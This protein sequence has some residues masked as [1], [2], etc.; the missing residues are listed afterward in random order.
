MKERK[1]ILSLGSNLG[2][3]KE[4][5][6]T[7]IR[8]IE[9]ILQTEVRSSSFYESTSWGFES[10]HPFL[11]NCV[12]L[13]SD[14]SPQDLLTSF[15]TVEKHMGRKKN[16]K[17]TRYVSRIIDIDILYVGDT[18]L[19]QPE[20]TIPHPLLYDRKFVLIPLLELFPD[21]IDPLKKQNI[22]ALI[23]TCNDQNEAIL[24][25]K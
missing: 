7:A 25:E 19:K 23:A 15:K 11:N 20:L 6:S 2:D 14:L 24:Y 3:R 5:L 21:W 22:E 17:K 13:F 9:N 4:N 8:H 16:V 12:S 1:V 18:I 10:E